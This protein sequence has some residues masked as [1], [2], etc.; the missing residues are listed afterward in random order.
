MSKTF[1]YDTSN[2][3][4]DER[5]QNNNMS[6][7]TSIVDALESGQ[8]DKIIGTEPP[9]ISGGLLRE[10][11]AFDDWLNRSLYPGLFV[12]KHYDLYT[13]LLSKLQSIQRRINVIFSKIPMSKHCR[14]KIFYPRDKRGSVCGVCDEEITVGEGRD[15]LYELERHDHIAEIMNDKML[16]NEIKNKQKER[17]KFQELLKNIN[18]VVVSG[19][20]FILKKYMFLIYVPVWG[21]FVPQ[22]RCY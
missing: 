8:I 4:E 19:K 18:N 10:L 15:F 6:D 7:I 12:V 14:N 11:N 16:I 21:I 9:D 3:M 13:K 2:N 1:Y 5:W 17:E 20:Y 22:L